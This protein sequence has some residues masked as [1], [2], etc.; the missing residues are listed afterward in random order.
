MSNYKNLSKEMRAAKELEAIITK[1]PLTI[2]DNAV[3]AGSQSDAFARSYALINP[4]LVSYSVQISYPDSGE[5]CLSVPKDVEGYVYRCKKVTV[6]GFDAL[7]NK[8]VTIK[9]DKGLI[10]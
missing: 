7:T 1:L 10:Y 9:S 4:E 5:G 8:E 6:K 2:S 3:F